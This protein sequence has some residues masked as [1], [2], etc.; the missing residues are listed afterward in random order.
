MPH[1][2]QLVCSVSMGRPHCGTG[3]AYNYI[4]HVYQ[5]H[6]WPSLLTAQ[7]IHQS[8]K[9]LPSRII[10]AIIVRPASRP[11]FDLES[12][13][14]LAKREEPSLSTHRHHKIQFLAMLPLRT[15]Y[16]QRTSNQENREAHDTCGVKPSS[17]SPIFP[18]SLATRETLPASAVLWRDVLLACLWQ[19][20]AA[21]GKT[22]CGS[23]D[24]PLS[25]P[26]L[27]AID[28]CIV[29]KNV[30]SETCKLAV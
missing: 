18:R 22:L 20:C 16:T 8:P 9:P 7:S 30:E 21:M 2:P 26:C 14:H 15:P 12:R 5:K 1:Q 24:A 29:R 3:G 4:I 28:R 6:K 13:T 11:A 23:N 25:Q 19:S 17:R 10:N 27:C